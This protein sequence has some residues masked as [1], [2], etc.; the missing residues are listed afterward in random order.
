MFYNIHKYI[1]LNIYQDVVFH[2]FLRNI[3]YQIKFKLMKKC[4]YVKMSQVSRVK[5][6]SV[7]LANCFVFK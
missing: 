6:S 2:N 1:P 7:K 3:F 4:I 5:L